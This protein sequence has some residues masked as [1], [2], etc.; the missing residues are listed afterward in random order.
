MKT[1]FERATAIRPEE[2]RALGRG[3][4]YAALSLGFRPP[5]E[6]TIA[7]LNDREAVAALAEAVARVEEASPSA[8]RELGCRVAA[9]A[10]PERTVAELTASYRRLFGH[11]A[12]GEVPAYET[13]Y[14]AEAL[15]QQPQE[16][17]DLS[18]FAQAF[19]LVL[20]P[21]V[22]E[23]IDHVSCE[24]EFASFLAWK[25][26]YALE[27]GDVE[28]RAATTRATVLFLRD[29]LGRFAPVF[30]RRL[31]RAD[32]EGFYA[33]L[34]QLLLAAVEADCRHLG[35]AMGAETLGLRPDPAACT[36]PMGCEASCGAA[37]G[38]P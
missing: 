31:V 38:S 19:G 9:L 4:L 29:H 30:A 33:T 1:R 12:R 11:T 23:R 36:A 2:E 35:V 15:F 20:R 16:L 3:V 24:C 28:A 27:T 10:R 14:G 5:T 34:G 22:H 18:G 8:E 25:E 26:A 13:E 7:R 6:E 17:G 37:E 32:G 21:D